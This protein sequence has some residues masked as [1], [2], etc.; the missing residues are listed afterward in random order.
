[1]V[2]RSKGDKDI[3]SYLASPYYFAAVLVLDARGTL[4]HAQRWHHRRRR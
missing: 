2:A 1:M 3:T 4:E